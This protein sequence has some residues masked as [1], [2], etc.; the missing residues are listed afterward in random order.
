M[1]AASAMNNPVMSVGF[2]PMA[3]RVET[4]SRYSKMLFNMV[5]NT[6]RIT[7]I[8]GIKM[9]APRSSKKDATAASY[10]LVPSE[11][12]IEK[13]CSSANSLAK[14]AVFSG[15]SI[16]MSTLERGKL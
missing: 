15:A 2:K 7:M 10:K 13:P 6:F 16:N 3:E 8:H 4:S 1:T 14:D 5:I 11:Y 12:Q 9:K